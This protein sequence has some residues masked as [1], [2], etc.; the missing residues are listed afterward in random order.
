MIRSVAVGS[1]LASALA[2]TLASAYK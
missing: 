1:V 2:L